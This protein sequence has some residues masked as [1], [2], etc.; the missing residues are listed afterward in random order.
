[1]VWQAV[2]L[3]REHCSFFDK[4]TVACVDCKPFDLF[5]GV[6]AVRHRWALDQFFS[7]FHQTLSLELN[8]APGSFQSFLRQEV[9]PYNTGGFS[10]VCPV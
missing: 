4:S 9:L 8:R 2:A 6:I 5:L 7:I 1:M 10:F 3:T